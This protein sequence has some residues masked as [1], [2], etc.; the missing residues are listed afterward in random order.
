MQERAP[1]PKALPVQIIERSVIPVQEPV[2]DR[3]IEQEQVQAPEPQ[4]YEEQIIPEEA[5]EPEL[6]PVSSPQY[7]NSLKNSTSYSLWF[8]SGITLI[9]LILLACGLYV[10][11]RRPKFK[12]ALSSKITAASCVN[13]SYICSVDITYSVDS[14]E[15]SQKGVSVRTLYKPGDN[16]DILYDTVNPNNFIVSEPKWIKNVFGIG[17]TILA[18]IMIISVWWYYLIR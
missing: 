9:A 8:A 15:Y 12:G 1:A 5:P 18:L 3:V 10:L 2:I 13:A 7:R 16:L 6:P 4:Y 11:I 14:K 17:L